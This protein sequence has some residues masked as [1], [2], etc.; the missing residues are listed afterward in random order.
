MC[1]S[2]VTKKYEEG[3]YPTKT[4]YKIMTKD[5]ETGNYKGLYQFY[6]YNKTELN[7]EKSYP[8]G[9]ITADDGTCYKKG[10]HA[11]RYY[12]DVLDYYRSHCLFKYGPA[13]YE[14]LTDHT[15]YPIIVKIKGKV[16]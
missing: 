15:S 16:S 6:T 3:K 7:E 2:R 10:F 5:K 9:V 1:L 13:P 8:R 4:G 12:K 14:K 11:I